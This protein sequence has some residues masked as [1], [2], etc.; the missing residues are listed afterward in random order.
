[1]KA[2]ANLKFFNIQ[3]ELTKKSE[4]SI[5]Q[6]EEITSLLTQVIEFQRKCRDLQSEKEGL[7]AALQ[8]SNECQ[9][10]LS[11]E[12]IELKDKY[13]LLLRA[14]HELKEELKRNK[15]DSLRFLNYETDDDCLAPLHFIPISESLQAEIESTLESEGYGSEFSSLN[16]MH[17]NT[18]T[19]NSQYH[20]QS[21]PNNLNDSQKSLSPDNLTEKNYESPS[22]NRQIL[23]RCS[24]QDQSLISQNSTVVTTIVNKS[25]AIPNKLKIVK[26]LEGSETLGK[27]K[28]LA[29][30]H[31][32]VILE[33]HTGVQ[34]RVLQGL[35][36]DIVDYAL[37]KDSPEDELISDRKDED[38]L[39][40]IKILDNRFGV[41]SSVF[42]FTTTSLSQN[43][44][45]TSVTPS[46]SN[47][48]LATGQHLP[49]TSI[50]S[51][52]ISSKNTNSIANSSTNQPNGNVIFFVF[53]LICLIY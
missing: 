37:K 3:D 46:F 11:T 32:G 2:E 18:L 31:L 26:P 49:I 12:L 21:S 33:S 29:T 36:K 41:T 14:F 43:K 45:I 22:H 52:P 35:D 51:S 39:K 24:S 42:T 44:D 15:N 10:E 1:M 20:N 23:S 38:K 34:N 48:Q 27:W 17:L 28:K 4:D 40:S 16:T 13:D 30:P 19:P 5:R 53:Y 8:L 47:L 50:S 7:E 6:Q 9:N 25:F